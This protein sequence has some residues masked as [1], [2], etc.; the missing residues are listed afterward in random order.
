V[1]V[2]LIKP[3]VTVVK[4]TYSTVAR[5]DDRGCCSCMTALACTAALVRA[6]TIGY[7]TAD[8]TIEIRTTSATVE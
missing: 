6:V 7:T 4:H 3:R 1:S 5:V 2:E 8:A